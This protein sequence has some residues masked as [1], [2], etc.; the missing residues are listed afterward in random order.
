MEVTDLTCRSSDYN[1]PGSGGG[2]GYVN[3]EPDLNATQNAQQ[4]ATANARTA[5]ANAQTATAQAGGG[6]LSPAEQT[7]NAKTATASAK[8]A[9]A[10][11]NKTATA[12]AG[13]PD[14]YMLVTNDTCED[15]CAAGVC[16]SETFY[17]GNSPRVQRYCGQSK[18]PSCND[19]VRG[20]YC[21]G[22]RMRASNIVLGYFTSGEFP[23]WSERAKCYSRSIYAASYEWGGIASDGYY[24]VITESYCGSGTNASFPSDWKGNMESGE[25]C[26][27]NGFTGLCEAVCES[28][29]SGG[30]NIKCN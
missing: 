25:T 23:I 7:A 22:E 2:G 15:T 20:I 8:T 9:T 21:D 12:N 13:K 29:Y 19:S 28:G 26:G 27:T 10:K 11:A 24:R 6:G 18:P 30:N 1:P 14:G 5:T 4:T 3:P 17:E 16:F